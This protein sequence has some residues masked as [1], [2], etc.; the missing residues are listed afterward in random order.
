MGRRQEGGPSG[1]GLLGSL[2]TVDAGFSKL[3]LSQCFR[4][5]QSLRSTAP[6]EPEAQWPDLQWACGPKPA[7]EPSVFCASVPQR[8]QKILWEVISSSIFDR[9]VGARAR[10]K[11]DALKGSKMSSRGPKMRP[12]CLP[13]GLRGG[14]WRPLGGPG[15]QKANFERFWVSFGR[16]FGTP[17]CLKSMLKMSLKSSSA[18][19]LHF[20]PLGAVLG[21]IWGS[22][23]GRFG[24]CLAV[25]WPNTKTL[26]FDDPLE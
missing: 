1:R 6:S 23:W 18:S 26:I 22:L 25:R 20:G 21:S 12:K 5:P 14:P 7:T 11:K 3:C 10:F 8:S 2:P 24:L 9:L 17:K 19:E 15:A 4:N 13:G 16:S